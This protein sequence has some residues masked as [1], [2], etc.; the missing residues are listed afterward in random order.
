V[1]LA[2]QRHASSLAALSPGTPAG[3][4]LDADGGAPLRPYPG[5]EHLLG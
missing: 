3:S 2:A 4:P 5:L 1:R